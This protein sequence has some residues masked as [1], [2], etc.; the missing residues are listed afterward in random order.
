MNDDPDRQES[1]DAVEQLNEWLG[2]DYEL[3]DDGDS[4]E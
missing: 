4:D 1:Q 3:L 2:T